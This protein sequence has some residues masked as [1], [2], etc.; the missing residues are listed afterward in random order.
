MSTPSAQSLQFHVV[1]RPELEGGY[2]V[3][4]PSLPGCITYGR[5][6][7][8]A[9][10]MAVEAIQGYLESYEKHGEEIPSGAGNF[11]GIVSVPH[12]AHA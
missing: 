2:T 11:I 10:E 1:F 5:T 6:I 12:C 9:E 7:K 3:I 4:V 8:K